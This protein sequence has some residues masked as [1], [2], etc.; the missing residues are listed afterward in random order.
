[1]KV[2]VSWLNDLVASGMDSAEI[3][4]RLT[5]AGLEAEGIEQIGIDWEKVFV[6][7]VERVEQHPDADRLVLATVRAGDDEQTVVTGAPNIAAGQRVALALLG[8]RLIDPYSEELKMMTLKA[9]KIRGVRSEGMVCSEKELGISSEHEGIMVLDPD[10]PVGTPLRD[11]L[12][13]DVIE[14]EITPNLVHAFSMIGIARELGALADQ[15]VTFPALADLSAGTEKPDLVQIDAPDLCFR[16]V[17]VVIENVNVE[18][19]PTW[20]QRRLN[21]AGVRPINNIVDI[22][23]YVML[24]WGQPLHA[25]DR[26]DLSE[27]RI[28]VRRANEGETMETLDHIE[29][30]LTSE[31]LVIAD[32]ER[33]VA[34]AGVMGGVD[35]EIS[36]DTTTLL[37]ESA[38]F[39]M[40]G[41]RQT[42][43]S[44][45]LRTEASA[46]FERGLDPNLA[47]TAAQRAT[48]L[49]LELCPEARITEIADQYPAPRD[50][51]SVT[52]PRTEIKRLLGVDYPDDVVLGVLQ[53]LDLAPEIVDEN[54]APAIRVQVPT[55]R[56][57]INLKADVVE[58]VARIIGYESLPETLP[59]GKTAPVTID[60][61]LEFVRGVQ[62]SLTAAGMNEVITYPMLDD[63]EL[64]LLNPDEEAIPTRVGLAEKP[65]I[66]FV[67]ALNPLRSEWQQMR[68]TLMP[69][70]LR[71]VSE[72]LKYN[73]LVS[74]FE[75]GRVYLP[76]GIDELPNERRTL[77]LAIAGK[78]SSA[79]LY[80]SPREANFF[81]LSG[82]LSHLFAEIGASN[83]DIRQASHPSLHP[84]RAAEIVVKN[85]VIGVAGEVHPLV[86]ERFEIDRSTRVSIA[87]IDI[88]L[89]MEL[90]L[91]RF[92]YRP[93]SRFQPVQQD[94]AIVVEEAT[95]SG[96][97]QKVLEDATQPLAT[98]VRLFDVYR[99]ESVGE[100]NK[101]LA[102]RVTLAAPDRAMRDK[103]LD[104]LRKRVE[105]QLKQQVSGTLRS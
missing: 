76:E 1:M 103:D 62:D 28:I 104:K 15:P 39:N 54:G 52:M 25:F 37:L 41:I 6:G 43:R 46:R 36:D 9:N 48:A 16:Y 81:D 89:L 53:R 97:V 3:A 44:Q 66:P 87:E 26:N 101:S 85:Q 59:V 19:S 17:G 91:E 34:I 64:A 2:P 12:G 49:I 82:A 38:S 100:G 23:N 22:T 51:K 11:Y 74:V 47:M 96:D 21:A 75:T 42:A 69:A 31:D 5:M 98:S 93:V 72:N 18:P 80:E 40:V 84:G 102:F 94:F 78:Y 30:S 50:Q 45:R 61:V 58:E 63:N 68:P 83:V 99:G 7:S 86:V 77:C 71:N 88:P 92:A 14:F 33:P 24:E 73:E 29:R 105:K 13:D 57:D 4:Q 35:S 10:A 8:A 70:I 67:K 32:A 90:G 20:M 56:N 79:D 60:P 95:P 27:G 65:A 55:Y